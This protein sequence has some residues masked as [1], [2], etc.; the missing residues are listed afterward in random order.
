MVSRD[1]C[2][3]PLQEAVLWLNGGLFLTFL[4]YQHFCVET[5]LSH[6]TVINKENPSGFELGF[7]YTEDDR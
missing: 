4:L 7:L 6:H 1:V 3:C 2:K 5:E